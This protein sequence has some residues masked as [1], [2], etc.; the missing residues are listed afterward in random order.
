MKKKIYS[1]FAAGA[2][3]LGMTGCSDNYNSVL[4][5]LETVRTLV[6]D[7]ESQAYDNG[8]LD[9][10]AAPT[11]TEVKVESNTR[12]AAEVADCNG[13]WCEISVFSGTGNGS[14]N[15]SVR[16]N[17]Q[18]LRTCYV[19]V[20]KVDA[21]G[22][23]DLDGSREITIR[24]EA[25]NV[26]L[27]PS[28]LEP[29]PAD[30][31][32][33]QEFEVVSNV[34]WTLTVAYE[35]NEIVKFVTVTPLSGDMSATGDESFAGT[36]DARFNISLQSNRTAATRK[37]FITLKSEV[38]EY[39]VEVLQQASEYTFDVSPTAAQVIPAEGDTKTFGVLSLSDWTIEC[40]ADWIVF[41]PNSGSASDSRVQ[42][43]ATILPNT[44]REERTTEIHF[45]PKDS[46]Y[47]GLSVTVLQHAFDMAFG[48]DM[49]HG[50]VEPS[51]GKVQYNIISRFNW[52]LVVPDWCSTEYTSGDAALQTRSGNVE[53]E[54]NVSNDTRTG[55]VIIVPQ[56]TDF[57]G[58]TINPNDVGIEPLKG[59]ITQFGGQ[60]AAVS[61]PWV[62]NDFTQ[63]TA[64]VEFSY[65]SPYYKI[66]EAGIELT[67][68]N[69]SES[70]VIPGNL[71]GPNSGLVS[72]NLTDL[73]AA[74]NYYVRSFVTD[75]RGDRVVNSVEFSFRTAGQRPTEPDNPTPDL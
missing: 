5:P 33:N 69:S 35:T 23:K 8:H 74:T 13:G 22:E 43:V 7:V 36:G 40:A 20:Y 11:T 50:V 71:D 49:G 60:K 16:E 14:F 38:S 67:S 19:R 61:V 70:K 1:L 17:M 2:I 10:G 66:T 6:L 62:L 54:K 48:F 47:S 15:I 55:E 30:N 45:K 21:Q 25:S 28:S 31:P 37:A 46:Q 56:P 29:F 75:E 24:Q 51:G 34:A 9:L 44:T 39:T 41:L 18:E 59:Y 72:I 73:Q 12:W 26:R 42:T 27:S 65:Y 4:E 63:T 53:V 3:A 52:E 68:E 57:N 32:Q 58:V 64:T